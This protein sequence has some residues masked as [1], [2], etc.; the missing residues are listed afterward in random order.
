MQRR[1]DLFPGI[2]FDFHGYGRRDNHR[3]FIQ[4]FLL[5]VCFNG[6]KGRY[7]FCLS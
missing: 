1:E 6:Y 2:V 7:V 4:D 5:F 3:A